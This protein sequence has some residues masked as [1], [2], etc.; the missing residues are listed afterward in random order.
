MLNDFIHWLIVEQSFDARVVNDSSEQELRV[1]P[2]AVQL[3]HIKV[4]DWIVAA[5]TNNLQTQNNN[6]SETKGGSTDV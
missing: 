2:Q 4:L 6:H 1:F 5:P 3:M